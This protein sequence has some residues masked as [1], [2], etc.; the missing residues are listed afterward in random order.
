MTLAISR[1]VTIP[2][3]EIEI[4]AVRS[5]GSGGQNVNKVASAIHL[6]FDITASSLP[7][8]Y[9][10]R[11]LKLSDKRIN[12]DGVVIIK[13]QRYRD[14]ERNRQDALDRLQRLIARVLTKP[15]KRIPT[16]PTKASNRRRLDSKT[17]RGRQK[18]LRRKV[19]D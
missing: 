3:S 10:E 2:D 14:Q 4:S 8:R 7:E 12:K 19:E 15:K 1:N 11:L 6:R 13:A 16:K 9:R 18:A 5:Q 17:R